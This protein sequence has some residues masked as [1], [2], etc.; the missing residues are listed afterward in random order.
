MSGEIASIL[1]FVVLLVIVISGPPLAFTMGTLALIF[2]LIWWGPPVFHQ[3]I[4]RTY[5]LMSNS[6]LVAVPLFIFMGNILERS[7]SAEKLYGTLYSLMG[8]LRGGLALATV[9]I[10]TAFAACTG[11]IAA[12]V[13]VMGLIAL[14]SMLKRGYDKSL[15]TG[16]VCAGS[17]LGILIPPSIMIVMLGPMA[18]LSVSRL[19]AAAYAPGLLLSALY[20]TY[21][22]VR[23][24]IQPNLGPPIS[25]EERQ[26]T[27][28][29]MFSRLVLHLLP[30]LFLILAV[31]GSI[32]SG[33]AAPTEASAF[34]AFGALVVAAA[35][36]NLNWKSLKESVYQT[37]RVSSMVLFV[38]V[39]ATLFT[40]VFFG[41][42]GGELMKETLAGLP[43]GRWFIFGVM[44]FVIFILGM[45][46]DWIGILF[47]IVPTFMPVATTLGFDPLW[48]AIII[49][50]NL[51]MSF[52]TPPFCT[53]VFFLKGIAPPEVTTMD[54]YKGIVPFVLLQMVGLVLLTIFPGI[55]LWLPRAVFG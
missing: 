34:G 50:V 12:S 11:V 22:S 8:S 45:F 54:I 51:Q 46:I 23:S 47:I 38:A 20:L 27:P 35:Y 49:C 39:G 26:A 13:S 48:F 4:N 55:V 33:L 29:N 16:A 31:M 15:A 10:A 2:G 1:M 30:T 32:L 24:F 52:L 41:L 7:G 36:R 44:M 25:A 17:T 37:L 6:V 9:L 40:G 21:I 5:G 3:F 43:F 28:G 14:P 19:F 18:G 53:T 42:G